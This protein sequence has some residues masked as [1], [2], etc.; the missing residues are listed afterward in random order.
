MADSL[1]PNILTTLRDAFT[2]SWQSSLANFSMMY[3]GGLLLHI[4][5]NA[6]GFETAP[7]PALFL[8]NGLAIG[9]IVLASWSTYW[10]WP[11]TG[12]E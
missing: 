4:V 11:R 5:I 3:C 1:N 10:I 6:F 9:L 8:V 12:Q 7:Y 2:Q